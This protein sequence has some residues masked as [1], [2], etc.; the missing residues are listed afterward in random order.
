MSR[1]MKGAMGLDLLGQSLV[2][3]RVAFTG[4]KLRWRC[5]RPINSI[6]IRCRWWI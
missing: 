4:E 2:A 5:F 1:V 3:G 6:I